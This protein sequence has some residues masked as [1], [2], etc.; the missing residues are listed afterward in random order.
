[1]YFSYQ[2]IELLPINHLFL[3]QLVLL[4][5]TLFTVHQTDMFSFTTQAPIMVKNRMFALS[6]VLLGSVLFSFTV[7]HVNAHAAMM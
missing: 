2:Q 4:F 7:H 5:K 1:M 3:S 6:S